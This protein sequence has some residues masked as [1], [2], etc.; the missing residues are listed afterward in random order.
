M[1]Q[2]TR[3]ARSLLRVVSERNIHSF[4][5]DARLTGQHSLLD[6]EIQ[7]VNLYVCH[8]MPLQRHE[9][10]FILWLL[11]PTATHTLVFVLVKS[12]NVNTSHKDSFRVDIVQMD[13]DWPDSR[14][15]SVYQCPD[16][17]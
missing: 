12:G 1:F 17:L 10:N 6:M 2:Y 8:K 7:Q 4:Q 14:W 13:A 15:I 16:K 9:K 11:S 5:S 3:C